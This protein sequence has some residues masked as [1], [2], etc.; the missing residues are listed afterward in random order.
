MGGGSWNYEKI[1][2]LVKAGKISQDTVDEAVRRML[3]AKFK[4]GLFENPFPGTTSKAEAAKLINTPA[5]VKLARQLDAESIVLLENRNSTLPL[6]KSTN[7][8]V[9][10]PMAHGFM[11]VRILPLCLSGPVARLDEVSNLCTV[12]RLRPFPGSIQGR[13]TT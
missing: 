7:V 8:A 5:A 1:P 13:D 10:G 2:A 6:R 3:R 4:L 11:N 12:R 9:I